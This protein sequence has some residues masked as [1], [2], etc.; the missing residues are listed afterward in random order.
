MS[1][2]LFPM[3]SVRG[4]P[5]CHAS[6]SSIS[7]EHVEKNFRTAAPGWSALYQRAYTPMTLSHFDPREDD[8]EFSD[9]DF[10]VGKNLPQ[11]W[12]AVSTRENT[13]TDFF[14]PKYSKDLP[15]AAEGLTDKDR[16]PRVPPGVHIAPPPGLELSPTWHE[17][18]IH[19]DPAKE[20][21]R[22]YQFCE[23]PPGDRVEDSSDAHDPWHAARPLPT[24]KECESKSHVGSQPP[25]LSLDNLVSSTTDHD[26]FYMQSE[27]KVLE[28][29][30]NLVSVAQTSNWCSKKQTPLVLNMLVEGS[31]P[32]PPIPLSPH[33][34]LLARRIARQ[35]SQCDAT[36]VKAS[37]CVDH[38]EKSAEVQHGES[39]S[40]STQ[41]IRKSI[42]SQGS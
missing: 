21:A 14:P 13:P 19:Q 1:A 16:W 33:P 20:A 35:R 11:G 6:I 38:S 34:Q 5:G 4:A 25:T 26:G 29:G 7:A 2:R 37:L 22:G 10:S 36:S 8:E 23:T 24:L 39:E 31:C 9:V 3:A 42:E 32:P 15:D 18:S 17:K 40:I 27:S 41:E 30:K 12:S 28:N